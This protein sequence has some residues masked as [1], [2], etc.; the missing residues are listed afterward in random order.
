MQSFPLD[1]LA[2]LYDFM[3]E[4]N[5]FVAT[6]AVCERG[7]SACCEIPVN[8]SRLE[9]EYIHRKTGRAIYNN[10]IAKSGHSPCPFL[11]ES[12]N[13]SI[14]QYRPYNCRTFHT[15]DNP[16]Y[17]STGEDHAVYGV[18]SFGYGSDIL[19]D[20]AA[21]IRQVNNGEY[22]DIRVYFQAE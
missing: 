17:C 8:V 1:L 7:C 11:A 20:L 22:H 21:V 16:K 3:D 5:R 10:I 6:F 19:A 14:Y 18:S 13:C 9:A 12:G 15:L 4:Y 2:R